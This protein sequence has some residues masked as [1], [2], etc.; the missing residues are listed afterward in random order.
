MKLEVIDL[1]TEIAKRKSKITTAEL[2]GKLGTSQQTISRKIRELEKSGLIERKNVP[3]GQLISL[4]ENGVRFLRKKYLE[5]R[6]VMEHSKPEAISLG[7]HV[8]SG[9]GEGK[10]YVGQEEYF[11][12]FQ[13]KL[14]FLP[15]LGTLNIRMKSVQDMRAKSEMEKIKPIIISGFKRENREF[16]EIRCYPCVINRRIKCAVVIPER[17]HHPPDILEI[18]SPANIRKELSVKDNDYVHLEM[19]T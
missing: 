2:A 13:E 9:S 4:N 16:G 17:T 6:S 5:L 14:G 7:G 3:K 1:I 8:V 18:I 15:F 11:T 10:Y 12:Q 19:R